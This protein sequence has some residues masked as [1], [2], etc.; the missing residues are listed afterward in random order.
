MPFPLR[1]GYIYDTVMLKHKCEWD[2]AFPESPERISEPHQ[3]CQELG[4]VDRCKQIEVMK[5]GV[6][7]HLS[8]H[9]FL[10]KN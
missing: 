5:I 8:K 7:Y 1:T 10:V 9:F 3:R 2:S 4:L 6:K